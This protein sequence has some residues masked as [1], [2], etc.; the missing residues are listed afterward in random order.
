MSPVVHQ[1]RVS[2]A[3]AI[4]LLCGSPAAAQSGGAPPT[5]TGTELNVQA[6][7][8][9][10]MEAYDAGNNTLALGMFRQAAAMHDVRAMMYL[11]VM[12]GTGRGVTKDYGPALNWFLKA[13]EGGN[14]QGMCN[15]GILYFQG[16]GLPQNYSEAL[17][18][19]LKAASAGNSDAA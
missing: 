7:V 5:Q 18:W 19:F 10:G 11:G 8:T 17:R 2:W 1:W 16:V 15:V 6:L 3:V 12:Y 14:S 13:A 9:R 4:A